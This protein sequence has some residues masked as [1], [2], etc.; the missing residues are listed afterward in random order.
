MKILEVTSG[1]P[2]MLGGVENSVYELVRR[3]RLSN[4]DVR[5]ITAGTTTTGL[6]DGVWRLPVALKIERS[7]GDILFCP[8]ILNA[9]KKTTFEV[10]HAHTPRKLFAEAVALYKLLSR[11]KFPYIVSI[12]L[13][14][15]SLPGFWGGLANVY[16]ELVERSVLQHAKYVVVQTKTN[17][18]FVTRNYGIASEK[19]HI[20]PNAVNTDAYHP[21]SIQA[22]EIKKKYGLQDRKIV[23]FVGRLTTQK[24]LTYLLHSIP[25]VRKIVPDVKFVIVGDGPQEGSLRRE[26][27]RLGV[28]PNVSFVGKIEHEKMP[29]IYSISDVFV[30]PSLSESFPNAM[31]EAMSMRNPVVITSVGVAP[32]ILENYKTAILV[33]PANSA[34]L[35]SKI[36][37]LLTDNTLSKKLGIAAR[38]LVRTK[39]SWDY[40]VNQSLKLY[41]AALD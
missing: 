28:E 1:Y 34:E 4:H 11:R 23:L 18:Q 41:K 9:L 15:T 37:E 3:L 5:V 32:E 24:G 20:L 33:R 40:V 36:T 21:D 19:I 14:N 2:P 16:Q 8:S 38:E 7:W 27:I 31:L 17:K 26:T 22:E 30:L 10:V 12:R 25:S 6:K 13:L 39:Y 35:A 29:E